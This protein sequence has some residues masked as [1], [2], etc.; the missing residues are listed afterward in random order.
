MKIRTLAMA[1]V[2]ATSLM[3][4]SACK[5]DKAAAPAADA[6]KPAAAASSMTQAQKVSYILGMNIGS[7]FK[8]N[9]VPLDETSFVAGIKTAI[10]DSEPKLSKEEMQQAMVTFQTEMQKKMEEAQKAEQAKLEAD[11][12]K[13]QEE[14]DKFLAENGKKAGVITT[15][16]GVQYEVL[17]EGKGEKP[18]A[19]DTVT[20]DYVGT[21]IDGKEFDSSI[22]RGE[23]ASFAV[24]AVIP[25]WSEALQLMPVGSKWRVVIPSDL[26][27]GAGGTGGDIGPNATL[28]FEITL[29]K[30]GAAEGD[31]KV[32][33]V[34]SQTLA[35]IEEPAK[36]TEEVKKD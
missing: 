14:G 28:V 6:A 3:T 1:T 32:E 8:A 35:P 16:S 18:K 31:K 25:G 12:K 36:P 34:D 10:D 11:S 4:L 21:L 19:S 13:N 7:Q 5:D 29:H 26:A 9:Q 24:D 20:V 33:A 2:A 17:T 23:P 22:K 15:K 27:Y 30:I